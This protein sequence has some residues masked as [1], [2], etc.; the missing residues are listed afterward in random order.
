MVTRPTVGGKQWSEWVTD[1]VIKLLT[2]RTPPES[3]MANI[4]MVCRLVSTNNNIVCSLP[5][6]DFVHKY[7]SVLAVET[8]TLGGYRIAKAVKVFEH[9]SY[10]TPC[11]GLSFRKRIL[12]IATKAGYENVALLSSIFV[13]D[14]M[15]ESGVSVIQ[16][17][18]SE[19]CDLLKNWR[20]V[21]RCMFPDQRYLLNKLPD[22]IKLTMARL[23]KHGCLMTYTCNTAQKFRKLLRE[24]IESKVKENLLA[25]LLQCV[26]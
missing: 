12:K 18:F 11:R 5:G 24:V 1:M 9:H 16:R 26:D 22:P 3:I 14:G 2:Y 23:A 17:T 13:A 20:N 4:L 19:G 7:R 21:T 25:S 8:K 10:D 6:V 15:V